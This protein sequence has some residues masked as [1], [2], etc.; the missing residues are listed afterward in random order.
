[1]IIIANQKEK[2]RLENLCKGD[3]ERC[4]LGSVM[5]DDTCPIDNIGVT[6][7]LQEG[8]Y[9]K[10][11]KHL[12]CH[13]AVDREFFCRHPKGMQGCLNPIEENPYCSYGERKDTE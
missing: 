4:I 6:E 13:S 12:Y 8:V 11:C 3:C 9:C 10:D 1:M 2:E 7:G 5:T